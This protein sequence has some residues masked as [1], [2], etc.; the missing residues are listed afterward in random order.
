MIFR[1]LVSF[2]LTPFLL[3]HMGKETYG[4]W[5]LA[6]SFSLSGLFSLFSLGFQ[7]ALIK[8]VA[9][10]TASAQ[11]RE[12]SEV[13]SATLFIYALMGAV[14]SLFIFIF[15]SFFLQSF[16][17]IP[18]EL[19]STTIILLL[20]FAVQ[21]LFELPGYT[22]DAIISGLQRF[23]IVATLEAGK[24]GLFALLV[25]ISLR[26]GYGVI[27]V[28]AS[29]VVVTFVHVIAMAIYT[30]RLLPQLRLVRT[31][32]RKVLLEM[33]DFTK[34]LFI[35]RVNGI[36]YNS[37]DK[38]IIGSL[39]SSTLVTDYDIAN[40]IH[41]MALMAA[42][43][44][45]SVVIPAASAFN[46]V[47]EKERLKIL[48]TKGTKYTL[49][50]CLPVIT[51]L[52]VL[53]KPLI[54][55]WISP[56]YAGTAIYARLFLCYLFFWTAVQLGWNMLVGVKEV[57]PIV[58]IQIFSVALNLAFTY[59]LVKKVGVAGAMLGTIIGNAVAFFPY[60][61]LML[62]RFDVSAG[63]FFK[64]VILSVYPQVVASGGALFLM[65][66][67]RY[68]KSLLEVGAYAFASLIVFYVLFYF[69][70]VDS[71]DKQ[72]FSLLVKGWRQKTV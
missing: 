14:A 57:K 24:T 70:G 47:N 20:L 40:R 17:T 18:P 12:L 15:S 4:V 21:V 9:E 43:L 71:D 49:A 45:P 68:P 52:F 2:S 59:L 46:A 39:L 72:R 10:Y 53:A 58:R 29:M 56:L 54:S 55:Y 60:L 19:V 11:H 30:R 35:L 31:F 36:I 38:I 25:V 33:I 64:T 7:G 41:S 3:L 42:G 66:L 61:K 65:T 8:Y 37:M 1:I 13:V 32:T 44:A 34:D 62:R 50:M 48:L 23:D 51:A 16:F 27:G 5:V 67:L 63:S 26:L 6:L 22:L 28:G 69:T